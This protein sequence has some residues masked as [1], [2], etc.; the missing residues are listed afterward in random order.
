[1]QLPVFASD[2]QSLHFILQRMYLIHEVGGLVRGDACYSVS[3]EQLQHAIEEVRS[4]TCADHG[5]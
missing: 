2:H 5:P 4:H 3:S 1:M